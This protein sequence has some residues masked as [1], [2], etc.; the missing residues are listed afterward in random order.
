MLG[1]V[2]AKSIEPNGHGYGFVQPEQIIAGGDIVPLFFVFRYDK[3]V[4]GELV[5]IRL[6]LGNGSVTGTAGEVIAPG[7]GG[8]GIGFRNDKQYMDE[9]NAPN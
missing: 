6:E 2:D 9:D 3:A 8:N 4:A 7:K 5:A 1:F